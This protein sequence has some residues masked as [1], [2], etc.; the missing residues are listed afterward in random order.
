MQ[1]SDEQIALVKDSWVTLVTRYE[2]AGQIFYDRLF[3]KNPDL[4]SLFKHEMET[5]NR[6][7]LFAVSLIITKL[8]KLDKV[9]EE[10]KHLGRRHVDYGVLPKHFEP[11]G[12]AFLAMHQ[13]LLGDKWT[14][15]L[16]AAWEKVYQVISKAMIELIQEKREN[17]S[18]SS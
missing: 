7:L 11:F 6:K 4:R 10:I 1:L 2:Q 16:E 9:K 12:E 15:E 5:Q 17:M 18:S 3:E 14:P 8:S 13:E